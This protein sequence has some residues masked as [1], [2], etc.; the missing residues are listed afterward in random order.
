MGHL[1]RILKSSVWLLLWGGLVVQSASAQSESYPPAD[2]AWD[3]TS[4]RALAERVETKALPLPT[5]SNEATKLVFERMINVDN[6]PLR[7][8]LNRELS[9]TIRFQRLDSALDPIHK[10]VVLYLNETKKGK[11]YATELARL[12]VYESKV[13]AALLDLSEPYLSTL[14]TDKRYQVHV[15][16]L[17]QVK[18]TA[19]QLYS[20]LVQGMTETRR[21]SKSDILRMIGGAHDGLPSFQP[22]FTDQDRQDL[23]QRLTQQISKTTDRE[24][25]KALTELRDAIQHRRIRT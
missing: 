15:T 6:I 11:P 9:T 20:D 21:Y 18:S 5:L 4:Y 17:D 22:I 8:G 23:V 3:G 24:L 16:Y 14:S 13:L 7:M 10:L 25:K 2:E 1:F 12:M 19:R